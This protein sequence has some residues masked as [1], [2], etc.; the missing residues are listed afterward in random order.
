MASYA[1]LLY[2]VADR[3]WPVNLIG[4]D[5][6]RSFG[7]PSYWVQWLFAHNRGDRSMAT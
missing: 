7:T 3:T 6:G 4:Y 2:H 5:I 1:P